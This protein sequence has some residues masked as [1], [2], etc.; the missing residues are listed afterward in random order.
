MSDE[1]IGL[2]LNM[3]R[4]ARDSW[5]FECRNIQRA[6]SSSGYLNVHA[7]IGQAGSGH[8]SGSVDRP[9]V[10]RKHVSSGSF[11]AQAWWRHV[12]AGAFRG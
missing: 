7:C 10:P 9:E 11:R 8:V 5:A 2:W 1:G 3:P 12:T 4:D 6:K